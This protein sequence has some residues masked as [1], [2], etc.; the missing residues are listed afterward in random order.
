VG[1]RPSETPRLIRPDVLL[2]KP[3]PLGVPEKI[4]QDYVE[5]TKVLSISLNASAALSRR[6]LQN[7]LR[8]I[9][10]LETPKFPENGSLYDEIE[11]VRDSKKIPPLT[12]DKLH[13]VRELGNLAAHPLQD[14][15][16]NAIVEVK[17]EEAELT[18]EIIN[19]LLDHY[20]VQV[21][22]TK[23]TIEKIHEKYNATKKQ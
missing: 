14:K 5:A 19:E 8:K 11:A 12:S 9:S 6:C 17:R 3:V 18:L 15:Y 1:F 16:T 22:K 21:P 4:E 10:S 20:Y 13:A 7:I 2:P 23:K